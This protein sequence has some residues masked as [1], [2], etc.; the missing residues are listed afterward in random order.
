MN[1]FW[2]RQKNEKIMEQKG[3]KNMGKT[4]ENDTTELVFILDKSGS[5]SGLEMDTIGGFNSMIE[6]QKTQPGKCLVSTVLFDDVSQVLAR[7]GF[8][9]YFQSLL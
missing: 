5:M 2:K 4:K 6:K 7:S 9:R 1:A 3:E 8:D